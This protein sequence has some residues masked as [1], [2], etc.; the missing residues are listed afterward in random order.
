MDRST[1][2]EVVKVI[3]GPI[4]QSVDDT[5]TVKSHYSRT[6]YFK[7]TG[8]VNEVLVEKGDYIQSGVLL[9]KLDQTD[10]QIAETATQQA[11]WKLKPD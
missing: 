6:V 5:G 10:R 11:R 9:L 1:A 4:A 7:S 2:G 8:R 3:T